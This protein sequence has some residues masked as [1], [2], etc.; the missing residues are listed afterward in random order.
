[1]WLRLR[2]K[3]RRPSRP[4]DL[5]FRA[6]RWGH[7]SVTL[8][9]LILASLARGLTPAALAPPLIVIG[10]DAGSTRPVS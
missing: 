2:S 6:L 5:P 4:R 8:G 10:A 7:F 9:V 1:M 3:N